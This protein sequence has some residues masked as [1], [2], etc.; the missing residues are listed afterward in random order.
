VTEPVARLAP[1]PLEV[2]AFAGYPSEHSEELLAI[3]GAGGRLE[4]VSRS[5]EHV[6]GWPLEQL[7]GRLLLDL[8]HRDDAAATAA[9]FAQPPAAGTEISGLENRWRHSDGSWRWLRWF[10]RS[11]GQH[12]HALAS[13][14]TQRR[15]LERRALYDALTGLPNR[16]LLED[17]L[18]Q[19]LA[20]LGRSPGWLA[21]LFIDLDGL[22]VVNDTIGHDAGDEMLRETA[23]RLAGALRDSDTLARI[24]GDEFLVVANRLRSVSE[25]GGVAQRLI[26]AFAAPLRLGGEELPFAT[27]IGVAATSE[28]G[29]AA[30]ELVRRADVAMYRAKGRGGGCWVR[31]DEQIAGEVDARLQVESELRLALAHDELRVHYQ[32]IVRLSDGTTVGCEALVRWQHPA[33]GLVGPSE[34]IGLAEENG[35]I[36]PIGA[37]VLDEACR[38]AAQWRREGIDLT[39]SVNVSPRQM[40]QPDFAELVRTTLAR[41][42]LQAPSLCLEITETAVLRRLE[43]LATLLGRLKRLGVRIA[44]DDFGSGFSSLSHLR[45]LPIDVIKIDGSFV[46]AVASAGPDRAIVA[47]ILS[48]GEEMGL[49]VIAECIEDQTQH[50]ALRRL[51]CPLGQ[52]FHFARP[53]PVGELQLDGFD[54]RGR[55][56]F[57]DPYVIREFMRQIGIPAR[58]DR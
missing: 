55:P 23:R 43:R 34:F 52:G 16:G 39:V 19:A 4:Q 7:Q 58:M 38:Q 28:A 31:F 25:V 2:A 57:G 27:S 20:A 32:P 9:A 50:E 14:V 3:V 46:R 17:R 10:A 5:W 54:A 30:Q 29:T 22:K 48:L 47:A 37:W 51:R 33:R 40:N 45:G 1:A 18:A 12:W 42:G 21:L 15:D 26:D 49:T 13:H 24:G 44:M 41:R 36:V 53:G 8:V 56:G 11:D 6:L 35:L